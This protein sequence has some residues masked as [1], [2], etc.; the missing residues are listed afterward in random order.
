MPTELTGEDVFVMAMAM[1]QIGKNFYEALAVGS[2]DAGVRQFCLRAARDEAQHCATFQRLHDGWAA[3]RGARPLPPETREALAAMVKGAVQPD[4][5]AVQKV[6][7]GG[8]RHDALA[9]AAQ[10]ERD[11]IR[12]Y[13]GLA[14]R[15]P[16]L[17]GALRPIVAQEN[18]HLAQILALAGQGTAGAR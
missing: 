1:E 10:M 3:A 6:A 13:Q 14:Q 5:Q 18:Q 8:S 17:A 2:D 16:D 7:V 15:L 12:F 9:M 11:A 4:P